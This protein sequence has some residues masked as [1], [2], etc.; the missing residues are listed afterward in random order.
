MAFI[1]KILPRLP[2]IQ[3]IELYTLFITLTTTKD[4][5]QN[6]YIF[7]SNLNNIY[8]INN[9]ICHPSSQHNHPDKLFNL[10]IVLGAHSIWHVWLHMVHKSGLI[11]A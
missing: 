3:P 7:T 1:A 8:L 4:Q 5:P 11:C 9:Q 2:N 6:T 10:A